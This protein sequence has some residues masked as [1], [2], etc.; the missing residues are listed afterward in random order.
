[1]TKKQRIRYWPVVSGVVLLVIGAL[2]GTPGRLAMSERLDLLWQA[3]ALISK[4]Q[5][6]EALTLLSGLKTEGLDTSEAQKVLLQRAVCRK[7]L[8]QYGEALA[9]F[10]VLEAKVET[11]EDYL[12]FWQGECFEALGQFDR[13]VSAYTHVLQ[14]ASLLKDSA[15]LRV[16]DLHLA[17]GRAR[18]AVARYRHLLGISRQEVRALVGLVE[19]LEAL[20]DSTEAR[21]ARLRL[22]RDYPKTPQAIVA[23]KQMGPLKRVQECFY[24]G[25]AY[26]KVGKFRKAA[27]LFRQIIRNA[28]NGNWR[29][30]AQYELGLMYYNRRDYRTAERAFQKAYRVYRVPRALFEL[31]R[32]SVRLGRDLEAVEQF[33]TF[34]QRYPSVTGAARALWNA[35]MA[36]ERRGR[37]RQAREIFLELAARYPR[38]EFADKGRW[39]AG[40]ALYKVGDYKEGGRTFLRLSRTTSKAYLRDQ[41]F[42]WAGKCYRRSGQEEEGAFWMQ[43]AAQGFP[44]SYYSARARA[45]LGVTSD[46]FPVV[47]EVNVAAAEEAYE[48]SAYLLKGD[49]LAKLGLYRLAEREYVRAG[50]AHRDNRFALGDLLQRYER[51]GSTY[52]ALRVSN[53]MVGVEQ[54]QGLRITLA[55]FRRLY[56]TYYWGEISRTA[57]EVDLDPNLIL[58]IIRQES[59]FNEEALSSAG[60]RGLMQVM[61][62]TGRRMARKVRM[63]GFS[64]ADLWEPQTSIRLGGRHLSDHLRYFDR[65][66]DRQLGLALSAYNAGLKAA[67]RWS[68]RLP[69]EDVDEFVESIPYR[70]TRNYVKL[71][72]R[73]YQVYSYLQGEDR[74]H[75]KGLL[76]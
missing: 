8:G 71:V 42:Y 36:N 39:R 52:Q 56:P 45:V 15:V 34:A 23:L 76:R 40:F 60:A 24:G 10:R 30:R 26:A 74:P 5:Y 3:E 64:T 21:K 14:M 51:I 27:A 6:R 29:G 1:M 43:R 70:E 25:V 7:F 31:G 49:V 69:R 59:A 67:R 62:A 19:A 35:A 50:R 75:E 73:N 16:A 48:P 58:A 11:V 55:S 57:R 13:A 53:W 47:P 44:M 12:V 72:Y 33:Q 65:S 4:G 17:Q 28:S 68:R 32:C 37:Y 9:G 63:A 54:R 61:P 38:S 18:D 2:L 46:V 66:K 41:G 22:V 20:G